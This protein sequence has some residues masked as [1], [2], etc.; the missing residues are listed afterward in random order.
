MW[1]PSRANP[2]VELCRHVLVAR[3]IQ[4]PPSGGEVR[5]QRRSFL[6]K[7]VR[8]FQVPE[9]EAAGLPGDE[10]DWQPID[11]DRRERRQRGVEGQRIGGSIHLAENP[12]LP[13]KRP[14]PHQRVGRTRQP[15]TELERCRKILCCEFSRVGGGERRRRQLLRRRCSGEVGQCRG[16]NGVHPVAGHQDLDCFRR[17]L[18]GTPRR[19]GQSPLDRR[20]VVVE[21]TDRA[22][23]CLIENLRAALAGQFPVL[24]EQPHAQKDERG[25]R[26]GHD[27]PEQD[28]QAARSAEPP[29][30]RVHGRTQSS[31][32]LRP[33]DRDCVE[34]PSR[35]GE[36]GPPGWREGG[37]VTGQAAVALGRR[38]NQRC[39]NT[40]SPAN[41]PLPVAKITTS[42][43]SSTR[44]LFTIR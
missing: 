39:R 27:C 25:R 33:S 26:Q 32:I 28:Q 15:A 19:L 8:A 7:R 12:R 34:P 42:A 21:R 43:H 24:L 17:C 6:S 22:V 1:L 38:P 5:V 36:E 30:E 35:L 23:G 2:R 31:P 29:R 14:G 9:D 41:R 13:K 18:G 37:G 40:S 3:T 10:I 4:W 20:E 44:F 11:R 16:W